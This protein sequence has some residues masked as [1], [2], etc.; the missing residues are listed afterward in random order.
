MGLILWYGCVYRPL[1]DIQLTHRLNDMA[2][3][4]W[5]GWAYLPAAQTIAVGVA[6]LK[7]KRAEP[8]FPR[9]LGYLSL[10]CSVFYLPGGLAVFFRSGPLAWNGLITWWFLVVAYFAWVCAITW[11]LYWKAIPHQEREERAL[12]DGDPLPGVRERPGV[13]A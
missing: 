7:D 8:V 1:E 12:V 9:W 10:W 3:F 2:W 5:V 11:G 4:I 13:P 6:I